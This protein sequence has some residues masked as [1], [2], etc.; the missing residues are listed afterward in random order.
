MSEVPATTLRE[1]TVAYSIF[2]SLSATIVSTV[3]FP[4]ILGKP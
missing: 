3:A 4:Y 1:H 2:V